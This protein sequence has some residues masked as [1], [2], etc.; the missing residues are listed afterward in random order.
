V[1]LST[2]LPRPAEPTAP[3]QPNEPVLPTTPATA[4][5]QAAP[6]T[7]SGPSP[8]S[9]EGPSPPAPLGSGPPADNAPASSATA[10]VAVENPPGP[11]EGPAASASDSPRP[12]TTAATGQAEGSCAGASQPCRQA[13]PSLVIIDSQSAKTTELGGEHG[14]DGGKQINGRKRHLVVDSLGL[15]IAVVV[16]SA[17]VDDGVAAPAVLG[18]L[19]PEQFPRLE[20]ILGDNKY[21]NHALYKWIA[22]HS[23][24]KWTLQI[25]SKPEGK[26]GF[27]PLKI[28]WVVERTIAWLGR[29]RRLAK[30]YERLP[31]SSEA[32]CK[33]AMIHL[34][35]KKLKPGKKSP[36]FKYPKKSSKAVSG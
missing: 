3:G 8:S 33:V 27:V 36:E 28:R 20:V 31:A 30:D 12:E 14:Y 24:G 9:S 26:T 16:T 15:L 10:V 11:T 34:L 5:G 25:K 32:H 13:T 2:P 19:D 6:L 21:H 17:K 18:Q 4:D 35:L 23:H 7:P 22:N 1:R 29:S